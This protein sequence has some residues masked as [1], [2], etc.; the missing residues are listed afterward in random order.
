MTMKDYEME[1]RI[2]VKI[3]AHDIDAAQNQT[4]K[5]RQAMRHEFPE[6]NTMEFAT[7][8][9]LRPCERHHIQGYPDPHNARK[10]F[11]AHSEK[12]A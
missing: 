5:I 11:H 8:Y 3:H 2:V 12:R 9:S 7:N 1:L 4:T 10:V 6:I